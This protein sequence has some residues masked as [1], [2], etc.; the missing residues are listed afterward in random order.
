MCWE[1]P[2]LP[3]HLPY[4]R[5]SLCACITT[6]EGMF[7]FIDLLPRHTL[8]RVV[9]AQDTCSPFNPHSLLTISQVTWS[10]IRFLDS[11]KHWRGLLLHL[12]FQLLQN[13]WDHILTSRSF[14]YVSWEREAIMTCI[15]WMDSIFLQCLARWD[16]VISGV[17][18]LTAHKI[19]QGRDFD[20]VESFSQVQLVIATDLLELWLC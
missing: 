4:T 15:L 12:Y 2:A 16:C 10:R 3:T 1:N 20:L 8:A 13:I 19:Y 17:I 6:R 11:S 9:N 5:K 14:V 18:C 7:L